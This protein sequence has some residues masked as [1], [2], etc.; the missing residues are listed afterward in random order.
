MTEKK[1]D[2]PLSLDEAINRDETKVDITDLWIVPY[3]DFMTVLMIFFLL[4]FAFA[5]AAKTDK[6]FEKIISTLQQE[7]GGTLNKELVEKMIEQERTE[8]TVSHFDDMIAKLNLKNFI[9][10][11]SNTENIKILFANPVLFDIGKTELKPQSRTLLHEVSEIFLKGM[12]NEI[13]VEGHTDNVPMSGR[14]KIKSNWELS[15]AR[16]MGVI[17]YFV[18]Q[19]KLDP[20]RFASAGYGEFRPMFPNTSEYNRAQNRRIELNILKQKQHAGN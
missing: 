4:M 2:G 9:T 14:G 13:V 3:A 11:N 16:A 10:V 5:F 18:D 19:E 8:Q 1:D 12:D 15:I 7:M 17:K 20:K 6:R